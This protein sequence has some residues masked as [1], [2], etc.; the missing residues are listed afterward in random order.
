MKEEIKN[1]IGAHGMWKA[2]L[3]NAVDSGKTEVPIETIGKDNECIFGKWLYGATIPADVKGSD[4]YKK[5]RELH[6]EFHKVA[7]RVVLLATTG[8]KNGAE[9]MI[10][11]G[12]EYTNISAKLTQTMMEWQNKV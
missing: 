11:P 4:Y 9:A 2:R 7:A 1:A 6:A 12:G 10:G 8:K 5:V 3:R